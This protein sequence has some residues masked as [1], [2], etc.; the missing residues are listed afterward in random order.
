MRSAIGEITQKIG[1]CVLRSNIAHKHRGAF[2]Q[3][4]EGIFLYLGVCWQDS[5]REAGNHRLW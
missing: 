1:V 4:K 2:V 5:F 3:R